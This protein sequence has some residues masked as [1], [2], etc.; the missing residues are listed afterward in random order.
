MEGW[1]NARRRRIFAASKQM[2]DCIN[3]VCKWFF[4]HIMNKCLIYLSCLVY[5]SLFKSHFSYQW[6]VTAQL[7]SGWQSTWWMEGAQTDRQGLGVCGTPATKHR[8]LNSYPT[9]PPP[10]IYSPLS[11]PSALDRH[12]M[13]TQGGSRHHAS[14][15]SHMGHW[16]HLRRNLKKAS[17]VTALWL[18][19]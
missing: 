4:L 9:P 14:H 3:P 16:V 8:L 2:I 11:P 18:L 1:E 15:H 13:G 5:F 17:H 12:G 19:F 7:S 6:C 10:P